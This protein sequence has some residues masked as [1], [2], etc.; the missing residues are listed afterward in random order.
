[1]DCGDVF[2]QGVRTGL[3]LVE[4]DACQLHRPDAI[5]DGMV[6]LDDQSLTAIIQSIDQVHLPQRQITR[7]GLLLYSR[8]Q[9][10]EL[11]AP[12]WR[13]KRVLEHVAG[14]VGTGDRDP[15]WRRQAK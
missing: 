10:K 5:R 13:T 15:L 11:C 1:M 4:D 2:A 12:A 14:Q 3:A 8:T 7:E 6:S 9:R